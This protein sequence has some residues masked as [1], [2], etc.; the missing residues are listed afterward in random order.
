MKLKNVIFVNEFGAALQRLRE[1]KFK[2]GL[3][4]D[5]AKLQKEIEAKAIVYEETRQSLLSKYAK[6]D[7]DGERV[8]EERKSPD[9]TTSSVVVMED[10]EKFNEEFQELL[11]I[12]EEY[13]SA[14]LSLPEDIEITADDLRLLEAI[15]ILPR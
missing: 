12:E 4:W 3:S 14:K 1:H 2:V 9:G 13:K 8:T 7:K 11:E 5:L 10:A 15:I 6:K